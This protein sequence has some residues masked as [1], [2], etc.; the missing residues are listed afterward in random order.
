MRLAL[1]LVCLCAVTARAEKSP[2]ARDAAACNERCGT[3]EPRTPECLTECD[4]ATARCEDDARQARAR[5]GVVQVNDPEAPPRKSEP[6]GTRWWIPVLIVAGG[7]V[8]TG[9]IV[10]LAYGFL[11]LLEPPVS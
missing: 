6:Q 2:C 10:G 4:A 1:L 5:L 3:S 8:V 9:L 11:L 7:I